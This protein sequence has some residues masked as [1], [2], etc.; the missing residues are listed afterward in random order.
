[1][2]MN[3]VKAVTDLEMEASIANCAMTVLS[4]AGNDSIKEFAL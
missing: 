1:M 2:T 4:K 3:L